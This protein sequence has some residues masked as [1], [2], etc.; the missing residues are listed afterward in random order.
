MNEPLRPSTLG[1]ILDRTALL[2]RRNFWLFVGVAAVPIGA[3]FAV[4]VPLGALLGVY[5][6]TVFR[7]GAPNKVVLVL[8][9]VAILLV[10]IPISVVASVLSQAAVARVAIAANMGLKL[11]LRAAFKSV[12]PR[13]WRYLGLMVLQGVFAGVIPGAI[14]AAVVVALTLLARWAGGGAAGTAALGFALFFVFVATIVVVILRALSYS[15]A[16]PACIV[17]EKSAWVS[18]QRSVK[19]SKGT[20]GRIFVMFLLVYALAIIVTV[21]GYIPTTILVAIATTVGHGARYAVFMVVFA[22]IVNVLVSFALQTIITPVYMIALVLF[23]YD[24]R[25]R[26]EGFDIEWM[27]EQAGLTGA[28][29]LPP[30]L[31]GTLSSEQPGSP[32][33]VKE[34]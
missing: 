3:I 30:L 9:V 8:A 19:L 1:E 10:V 5:G 15:M 13:F 14:A 11:K 2:F 22:E 34:L 23:Y 25:I 7:G 20:R 24:Q 4:S 17:E 18:L 26:T 16:L 29:P 32:D 33:T 6:A 28:G 12:W 31:E 27:M 21:I